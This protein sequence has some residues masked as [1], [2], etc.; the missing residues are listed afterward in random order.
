MLNVDI[1]VDRQTDG[2]TVNRTP[3]SHPATSRCDKNGI[4]KSVSMLLT[5][6]VTFLGPGTG[7]EGCAVGQR[8]CFNFLFVSL[9]V[10]LVIF[11]LNNTS[12]HFSVFVSVIL[13]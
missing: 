1:N 3:I 2:R 9:L 7:G 4:L 13:N 12:D 11:G 10:P 8:I 6:L 5:F